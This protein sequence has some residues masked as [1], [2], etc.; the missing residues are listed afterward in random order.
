VAISRVNFSF[1]FYYNKTVIIII[2][3]II[4]TITI[5]ADFK[6][7]HI[8]CHTRITFPFLF[9]N[10]EFKIKLYVNE[11]SPTRV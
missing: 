1:T 10:R 11:V 2:I 5:I 9:S 4:I 6:E 3:I 7:R 8:L